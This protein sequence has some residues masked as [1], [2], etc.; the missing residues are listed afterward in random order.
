[1]GGWEGALEDGALEDGAKRPGGAG[2]LP[3]SLAGRLLAAGV[4]GWTPG[5]GE[6]CRAMKEGSLERP[7]EPFPEEAASSS[8][9]AGS[10]RSAEGEGELAEGEGALEG[11]GQAE[12]AADPCAEE[13][14]EAGPAASE[15]GEL[16]ACLAGRWEAEGFLREKREGAG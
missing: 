16:G 15:V 9:S 4:R 12:A 7:P 3:E 14:G 1:M 5:L 13:R 11:R 10:S 2:R 6:D 8:C